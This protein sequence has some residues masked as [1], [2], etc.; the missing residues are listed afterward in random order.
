MASKR[1]TERMA[2]PEDKIEKSIRETVSCVVGV[3]A[4]SDSF[5]TKGIKG[6][7]SQVKSLQNQQKA[8]YKIGRAH[9]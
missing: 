4:Q 7:K 6:T 9:V 8:L 3:R 1:K 2:A 5:A